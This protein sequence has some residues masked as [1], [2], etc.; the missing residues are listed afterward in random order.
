MALFYLK[1][2]ESAGDAQVVAVGGEAD[3]A[4]APDLRDHLAQAFEAGKRN[5]IVDLSEA[6]FIDST[7]IGV[8]VS[9]ASQVKE[10]GGSLQL[11]CT[12]DKVLRIFEVT[13]LDRAFP[14][15]RTR[16]EAL[17]AI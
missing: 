5:L 9:R 1:D 17:G 10:A 8:L 15:H 12:N 16:A 4:C 6:S 13:G 2:G 11:V 3:F 7:V 14:I